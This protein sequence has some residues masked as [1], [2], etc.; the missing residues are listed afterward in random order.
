MVYM[1]WVKLV[2]CS[3]IGEPTELPSEPSQEVVDY[4]EDGGGEEGIF[5]IVLYKHI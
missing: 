5:D 3:F 2:I 4:E 1:N